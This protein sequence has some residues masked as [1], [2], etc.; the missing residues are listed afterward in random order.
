MDDSIRTL[1]IQKREK[2]KYERDN[3]KVRASLEGLKLAAKEGTNVMP[4]ILQSVENYATLGEVADV[5]RG[6]FGEF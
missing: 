2:L 4:H 5:L 3:E 1:Q 6:V